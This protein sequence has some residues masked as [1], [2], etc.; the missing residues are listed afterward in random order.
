[1]FEPRTQSYQR[2]AQVL[3]SPISLLVLA[4]CGGGGG[5]GVSTP[6]PR[7]GTVTLGPLKNAFAFLDTSGD[8]KYQDGEPFIRTEEDGSYSIAQSS[9]QT[10]ATL[11][12]IADDL[13]TDLYA[14]PVSGITLKA[15]A[16]AKVVSMA[17]TIYQ[18]AVEEGSDV[19]V[20]QVAKLLGIDTSQLAEGESLL[21]FNPAADSSSAL[22]KSFEAA[23]KQLSAVLGSMATIAD[24]TAGDA[25]D[26]ED[27]FALALASVTK[28]VTAKIAENAGVAD[29]GLA[30]AS[31]FLSDELIESAATQVQADVKVAVIAKEKQAAVA[32]LGDGAS[33]EEIAAAEARAEAIAEAKVDTSFTVIKDS[34]VLESVK[35]MNTQV[36]TAISSLGE[37]DDFTSAIGTFS[38]TEILVDQIA[39][40]AASATA[41][42]NTLVTA[43]VDAAGAGAVLDAATLKSSISADDITSA[44][45][46]AAA[47]VTLDEAAIA[48][49]AANTPPTDISIL[50]ADGVTEVT[51]LNEV[52]DV[53]EVTISEGTGTL[54]IGTLSAEDEGAAE[55]QV[56]TFTLLG[57]DAA[58]FV[59]SDAGVLSFAE[60]PVYSSSKPSLSFTLR[61][62]DAGGKTYNEDFVINIEEVADP[63][64][65]KQNFQINTGSSSDANL[66]DYISKSE[67]ETATQEEITALDLTYQSG[68]ITL[69]DVFM[70]VVN[71]QNSLS[72]VEGSGGSRIDIPLAFMPTVD[73]VETKTIT[74]RVFD[75]TDGNGQKNSADRLMEM[76]F[77][78]RLT[79]SVDENGDPVTFGISPVTGASSLSFNYYS[80]GSSS[81]DEGSLSLESNNTLSFMP[82]ETA[83]DPSILSIN[84]LMFWCRRKIPQ[85]LEPLA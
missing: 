8:G 56:I 58:S 34:N 4:A 80:P 54:V 10:N 40:A 61:A 68:I 17:S 57:E 83:D 65:F 15:P 47:V 35:A 27:A 66:V 28:V 9:G 70:D 62:T 63:T 19:S 42:A 52:T 60:Q 51:T 12:A 36:Q 69:P 45:N 46:T 25:V 24:S 33:L 79:G 41:S 1:M 59:I 37:G 32:D 16:T 21:D 81:P 14:G 73:G 5:S 7:T 13:T 64:A 23:S 78:V 44:K 43:L 85:Y 18:E 55:D 50:A 11:V 84:P 76:S 77:Q 2:R 39:T 67:G 75:D 29:G 38:V 3:L 6:D 20:E 49:A 31:T 22:S 26:G 71:I 72:G 74:V 48:T 53:H 30:D 82:G